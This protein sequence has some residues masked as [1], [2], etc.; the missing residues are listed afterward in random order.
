MISLISVRTS[1]SQGVSSY[2]RLIERYSTL[3]SLNIVNAVLMTNQEPSMLE[4]VSTKVCIVG[5]GPAAHT[6]AIYTA[7]AELA[8]IVFE[9]WMANGIA[10]G[11]EL[12]LVIIRRAHSE[13]SPYSSGQ[14]KESAWRPLLEALA[15]L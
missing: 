4:Q 5:S 1:L 14:F 3:A 11:A 12:L 15:Q 8:P 10:A 13:E 6:A 7:R 9:G 2:T